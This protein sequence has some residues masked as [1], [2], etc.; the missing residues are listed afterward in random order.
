LAR[1]TQPAILFLKSLG[2]FTRMR[3]RSTN[4]G[5]VRVV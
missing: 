1:L 5:T 3:A 4:E 2:G